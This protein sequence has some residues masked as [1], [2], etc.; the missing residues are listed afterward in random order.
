MKQ[1]QFHQT[2]FALWQFEGQKIDL[3]V[4]KIEGKRV[5][6][7]GVVTEVYQ[8]QKGD[9]LVRLHNKRT[10]FRQFRIDQVERFRPV[11]EF[12]VVANAPEV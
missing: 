6:R 2:V 8:S 1:L 4:R 5:H 11:G 9:W 3:Y 12:V 7:T 10:G